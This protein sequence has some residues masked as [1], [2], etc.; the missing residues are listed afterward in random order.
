[1][2]SRVE[3]TD[4]VDEIERTAGVPVNV[5]VTNATGSAAVNRNIGLER[6]ATTIGDSMIMVDDDMER[7]P[8]GWARRL[9]EVLNNHPKCVMV[10]PQL[11]RPNGKPGLMIG[12]VHIQ[13]EGVTAARERRLPTACV[14][15]RRNNLR[16]DENY[17]GSGFEDDDYCAQLR[18][19]CPNAQF[20]VCHDLWIVHRNEM[21][22]QD[23][24]DGPNWEHNKALYKRKWGTK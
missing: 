17:M 14:A 10:S 5:I 8:M 4:L 2:Q 9:L 16:F 21:K 7:F 3:L 18:M 19:C 24:P 23:Y 11:A 20:L 12:G 13:R 1:M 6:C 15:I 22:N